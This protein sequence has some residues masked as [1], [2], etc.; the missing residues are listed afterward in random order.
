M[1]GMCQ[2]VRV[3]A[4]DPDFNGRPT[5]DSGQSSGRRPAGGQAASTPSNAQ[6]PSATGPAP[7]KKVTAGRQTLS[8]K[9]KGKMIDNLSFMLYNSKGEAVRFNEKKKGRYEAHENGGEMYVFSREGKIEVDGLEPDVYTITYMNNDPRYTTTSSV[10]INAE[11]GKTNALTVPVE[12]NI[13]KLTIA[14]VDERGNPIADSS[15]FVI[16]NAGERLRFTSSGGKYKLSKQGSDKLTTDKNGKIFIDEINA[17]YYT[18]T[19]T[20]R[21]RKFIGDM[22]TTTVEVLRN[23]ETT[24]S[25]NNT[26]GRGTISIKVTDNK[27]RTLAGSQFVLVSDAD[28]EVPMTEANAG[29]FSPMQEGSKT[30][31]PSVTGQLV[32]T[33]LEEGDYTLKEISCDAG[34]SKNK[35]LKLKVSSDKTIEK[36]IVK[37]RAVGDA[38]I[39]IKDTVSQTKVEGGSFA[40]KNMDGKDVFFTETQKGIYTFDAKGKVKLLSSKKAVLKLQNL[41]EGA[42][43]F[44]QTKAPHGFNV[45]EKT[46][47]LRIVPGKKAEVDFNLPRS[48]TSLSFTR[49]DFKPA[50]GLNVII[51]DKQGNVV[52]DGLTNSGG[53]LMVSDVAAGDY[54]WELGDPGTRYAARTYTGDFS[55]N[56]EGETSGDVEGTIALSQLTVQGPAAAGAVYQLSSVEDVSVKLQSKADKDGKA[57]FEGMEDGAYQLTM[58]QSPE[59]Y[60]P[61]EEKIAVTVARENSAS[62]IIEMTCEADS[63]EARKKEEDAQKEADR[64][65]RDN[66]AWY[67]LLAVSGLS[68]AAGLIAWGVMRR[69]KAVKDEK[70]KISSISLA[71]PDA[72]SS[73]Q[74]IYD[75]EEDLFAGAKEQTLDDL[76]AKPDAE[77]EE[78]Q[79]EEDCIFESSEPEKAEAADDFWG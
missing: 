47:E 63:E 55:I 59:G 61:S 18:I 17:T 36:Q 37:G 4:V 76:F 57:V 33:G 74:N 32:I 48:N 28:V 77:S 68:A 53:R 43:E 42:Y 40:V 11:K 73:G 72:M 70:P 7:S 14:L 24:V 12:N 64:S 51:K 27:G 19:Q 16:S 62:Q 21:P 35:P 6:R 60:K 44:R 69:K 75:D 9:S 20:D 31:R 46:V 34:Y 13:G 52:C 41:P 25:L 22:A 1:A 66:T 10:V 67:V 26:S 54:T 78:I 5:T 23:E 30:M 3:Y 38:V 45:S 39:T 79:P 29:V 2:P 15:F 56:K 50:V 58:L 49:S 65:K 71:R 8:I